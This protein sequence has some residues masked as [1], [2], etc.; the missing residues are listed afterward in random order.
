MKPRAV[1]GSVIY[2]HF[3][4]PCSYRVHLD[5]H[6]DRGQRVAP[7]P[8]GR[9][10]MER[11]NRHETEVFASIAAQ[12]P[13][14]FI[15]IAADATASDREADFARRIAA[16]E[17][18]MRRGVRFIMH[19]FLSTR[20]GEVREIRPGAEERA[21]E[22][23]FRGETDLLVRCDEPS[24]AYGDW[25]Y[26]VGDVKSSA[27]ARFAQKMQVSFY[28]WI[29]EL[30]QGLLPREGFIVTGEGKRERF[31]LEET[32]WTLRHFLEEEIHEYSRAEG[33]FY[34]L[35]AACEHC[36]WH[37]ICSKRAEAEDDLSLVPGLRR[38]DKR[39]LIAAGI[40][41]RAGF[42][43]ESDDRLR[44]LG[45]AYGRRLDGFRELRQR[46]QAQEFG[47]ALPR[48]KPALGPAPKTAGGPAPDLFRHR[49]PILLIAAMPDF[50]D[51]QE[52][53]IATVLLRRQGRRVEV[54]ERPVFL[55]QEP[56]RERLFLFG[57]FLR[58]KQEI[59]ALLAGR[60]ERA[61]PV[62]VDGR[63]A[64]R[65]RRNAES[66]GLPQALASAE[67]LLS[68]ALVLA[69]IVEEYY[70]LPRPAAD[71]RSLA[72]AIAP[73]TALPAG[74][75]GDSALDD[76][77]QRQ[78]TEAKAEAIRGEILELA[79]DFELAPEELRR[80]G[81]DLRP[82]FVKE[83]RRH[84]DRAWRQLLEFELD[85]ELTAGRVVLETLLG[86]MP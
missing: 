16:T 25:S 32:I 2:H 65:M 39:T 46:A 58:H 62:F 10:L 20:D 69:D 27:R 7:G 47:R 77:L 21:S 60:R 42:R 53:V 43:Q 11:G 8:A 23:V 80:E 76:F 5:L 12:H 34:Q 6:G 38:S 14:D 67:R 19:G 45:R 33:V 3:A 44:K 81:E 68:D 83:W 57:R 49:G 74:V 50:Y 55:V 29:L 75:F 22:L 40:E 54:S 9:Y 41:T 15:E 1:T 4:H 17:D 13:E 71:A 70:Y 72:E 56:D 64:W 73:G 31:A 59:D 26:Q 51:G 66:S 63:S 37:D 61:L 18:A 35:E 48:R 86:L 52:A 85:R 78:G 36:H 24:P 28:S 82:L 79:A 30:R 84:P